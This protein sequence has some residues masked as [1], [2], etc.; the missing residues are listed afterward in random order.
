MESQTWWSY[1]NWH[2]IRTPDLVTQG[3]P[4]LK[5]AGTEQEYWTFTSFPVLLQK[6]RFQSRD[7]LVAGIRFLDPRVGEILWDWLWVMVSGV[8]LV[9]KRFQN[10]SQ[11][12]PIENMYLIMIIDLDIRCSLSGCNAAVINFRTLWSFSQIVWSRDATRY[13]T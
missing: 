3:T 6:S 11:P 2:C 9:L 5:E 7:R 13:A 10:K 1:P 12:R 8:T 4:E